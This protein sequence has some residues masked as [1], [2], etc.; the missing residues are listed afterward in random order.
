MGMVGLV[1]DNG[2]EVVPRK[3]LE[4]RWPLQGLDRAD[5]YAIPA[6]KAGG[7]GFF[8]RTDEAGGALKFVCGLLQ[9]LAAMGKVSTRGRPART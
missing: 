2:P 9:Q 8:H 3:A 6:V 4:P 7:F 5:H 1:D